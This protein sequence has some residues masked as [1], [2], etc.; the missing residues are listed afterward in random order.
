MHC[1][2]TLSGGGGG[3]VELL[4][5]CY[6]QLCCWRVDFKHQGLLVNLPIYPVLLGIV[7]KSQSTT[8]YRASVF[9]CQQ[10]ANK[11]DAATST[12]HGHSRDRAVQLSATVAV[13]HVVCTELNVVLI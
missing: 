8:L 4:G 13:S 11:V 5:E 1:L 2:Y 3:V 10:S 7:E 12:V 6:N 9:V